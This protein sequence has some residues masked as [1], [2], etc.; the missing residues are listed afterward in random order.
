M[1]EILFSVEEAFK[2]TVQA[3]QNELRA[4]LQ[5][6]GDLADY[7]ETL[8]PGMK[9]VAVS[10]LGVVS[11]LGNDARSFFDA[12]V[13]GRSGI[14]RLEGPHAERLA[15]RIGGRGRLRRARALSGAKLRM[16]DRVSQFALA[17]AS[18]AVKDSGIDF[19][20]SIVPRRRL[21]RHGHGRGRNHRRGIPDALCEQS[22]RLKPFTVLMAMVNAPARGSASSTA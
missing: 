5:T 10:G 4:R 16:L 11:P 1:I 12:L 17:A 8:V 19:A 6:F 21:R 15:C 22:D 14:R 18:Q 7:I 3:E 13:Q 20:R 2:I 9:R